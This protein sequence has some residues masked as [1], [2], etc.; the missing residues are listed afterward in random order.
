M[1]N[2]PKVLVIYAHPDPDESIANKA[3]LSV[4]CGFEH[5]TVHDLYAT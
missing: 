3:L 2:T 4:V 1:S 5:V